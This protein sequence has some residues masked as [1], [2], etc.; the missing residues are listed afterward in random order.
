MLIAIFLFYA[1]APAPPIARGTTADAGPAV[2]VSRC[3]GCHGS[4]G[5]G[6]ELGPAIAT[7]VP[8]RTDE[9]S[10][11]LSGRD[12]LRPACRRLRV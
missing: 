6:G 3:A 9:I 4:D 7:R 11:S 2:F 8:S 12:C 5:N 1:F 10:T